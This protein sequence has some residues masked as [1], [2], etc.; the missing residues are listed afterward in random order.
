MHLEGE[1]SGP[2]AG[3]KQEPNSS[4]NASYATGSNLLSELLQQSF[5]KPEKES[6]FFKQE[7]PFK[8]DHFKPEQNAF[9]Q[10]NRENIAMFK[11]D[12]FKD[13]PPAFKEEP[14]EFKSELR[15]A[16]EFGSNN[17][18]RDDRP[19]YLFDA[20]N[21]SRTARPDKPMA[22]EDARKQS[23]NQ[24]METDPSDSAM[25]EPASGKLTNN[26]NPFLLVSEL[27]RGKTP[28]AGY[29]IEDD[30]YAEL[31]ANTPLQELVRCALTKQ[32]YSV[33][34][35]SAAKGKHLILLVAPLSALAADYDYYNFIMS[36]LIV[37]DDFISCSLWVNL[38]LIV[39]IV[40]ILLSF[41]TSQQ[42]HLNG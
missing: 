19:D 30:F 8:M 15:E 4:D 34:D 27:L 18:N 33:E 20:S 7:N 37:N 42:K 1:Q 2:S 35:C 5:S 14:K 26:K 31:P 25:S 28:A 24:M 38:D 11:S 29:K 36:C 16:T 21:D 41:W 22:D 12:P 3:A 13:N 32:G 10:E 39:Y 9:K 40:K 17:D 6:D 23:A